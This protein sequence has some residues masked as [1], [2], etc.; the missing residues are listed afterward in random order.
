M[1]GAD[2]KTLN[3]FISA[4][5]CLGV[6]NTCSLTAL[7]GLVSGE[8]QAVVEVGL[9]DFAAWQKFS[10]VS[11]IWTAMG[12]CHLLFCMHCWDQFGTS[13]TIQESTRVTSA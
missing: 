5:N 10:A 8:R 13:R 1:R 3:F 9:L 12:S 6:S 2:T 7:R 4:K 11:P